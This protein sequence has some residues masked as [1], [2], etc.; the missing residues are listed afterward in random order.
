VVI[1]EFLWESR[2]LLIS[3]ISNKSFSLFLLELSRDQFPLKVEFTVTLIFLYF[4]KLEK[5]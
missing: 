5:I 1:K 3:I 4:F 2:E